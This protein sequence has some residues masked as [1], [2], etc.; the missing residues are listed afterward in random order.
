M[1]AGTASP[2][3]PDL[4]D[5]WYLRRR[6]KRPP[7][8]APMLRLLRANMAAVRYVEV[9]CCTPTG[10]HKAHSS[11]SSGSRAPAGRSANARSPPGEQVRRTH[12]PQT[13]S[14]MPTA[15]AASSA[16]APGQQFCPPASLW[17]LLEPVAWKAGTAGSEGAPAQQCAGATRR[18]VLRLR[19]RGPPATIRPPQR[20]R[21]RTRHPIL[22]QGLEREP[23]TL[24]VDQ[25]RRTDPRIT[26]KTS[27]T[28][29]RRTTLGPPCDRHVTLPAEFPGGQTVNDPHGL[30]D[31][32]DDP[33]QQVEDVARVADLL[34][35]VA[36]GVDDAGCP[37]RLHEQRVFTV[38]GRLAQRTPPT[39]TTT[40]VVALGLRHRSKPSSGSRQSRSAADQQAPPRPLGP[41]RTGRPSGPAC[42]TGKS[43]AHT[44]DHTDSPDIQGSCTWVDPAHPAS[45]GWLGAQNLRF[46]VGE[47]A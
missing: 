21:P 33:G 42:P 34:G 10:N 15:S 46:I 4:A 13:V 37:V 6:R 14:Y 7:L 27:T 1:V 12:A 38:P 29:Y 44:V 41:R 3:D 11:G 26:R 39:S 32:R 5:Y 40:R 16:Q 43:H 45:Q 35:P 9:C 2:D 18:T 30:H 8:G 28:N 20:P 19:H 47:Q 31:D 22:G 17:G 36:G 23:Q 25:D 24:R